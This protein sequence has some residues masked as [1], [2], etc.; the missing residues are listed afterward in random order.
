MHTQKT[1]TASES[2]VAP[3][4][5]YRSSKIHYIQDLINMEPCTLWGKFLLGECKGHAFFGPQAR[6]CRSST[7][8]VNSKRA[9]H[10]C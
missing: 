1:S 2:K 3:E 9:R 10:H 5:V 8:C 6:A 7:R 4:A